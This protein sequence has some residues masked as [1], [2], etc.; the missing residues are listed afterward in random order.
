[1]LTD[2]VQTEIT[3]LNALSAYVIKHTMYCY[4]AANCKIVIVLLTSE[5][6]VAVH[7]G[8]SHCCCSDQ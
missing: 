1:M 2:S 7:T 3:C 8:T 5:A 6:A 4:R